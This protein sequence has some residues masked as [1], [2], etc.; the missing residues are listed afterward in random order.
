LAT[1]TDA[2][3]IVEPIQ[4]NLNDGG[5]DA[6][7]DFPA[8][9]TMLTYYTFNYYGKMGTCV[10]VV[11]VLENEP[12]EITCQTDVSFDTDPGICGTAIS[13]SPASVT[14]NCSSTIVENNFGSSQDGSGSVGFVYGVGNQWRDEARAIVIANDN[15]IYYAGIFTRTVDFNPD[16]AIDFPLT[17]NANSIDMYIAKMDATGGF[18]WAKSFGGPEDDWVEDLAID[19]TGNL[20]IAGSFAGVADLNPHPTQSFDLT[21]EG[22]LDAFILKLDASGNFIWVKQQ[23]G[24]EIDFCR[25]IDIEVFL[26]DD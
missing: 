3:G 18:L 11:S 12:P 8:G 26:P 20:F 6:S 16:P 2:C 22:N 7:G 23:G 13:L 4:N 14:D 17:S 1:V 21:S 15:S 10:T 19:N 9:R 25:G 24:A 5:A